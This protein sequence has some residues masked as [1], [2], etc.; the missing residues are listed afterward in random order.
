MTPPGRRRGRSI[1]CS[2]LD[3]QQ[4]HIAHNL[5]QYFSPN[6]HLS[7]E[8][9]ALYVAGIVLPELTASRQRAHLGRRV[10]VDEATRQV[11]ADGG[12]AELSAHYHRYST[13]FYLLATLVARAAEMKPRRCWKKPPRNRQSSFAR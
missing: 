13:D 4:T 7:G 3:R 1:F 10:L 2:A 11:N 8:A 9:L 12:H 5:S 6:T